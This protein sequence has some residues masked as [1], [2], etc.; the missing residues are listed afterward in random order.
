MGGKF[1]SN[2]SWLEFV[3]K[4]YFQK[5]SFYEYFNL[6][7]WKISTFNDGS[8]PI[9]RVQ[10]CDENGDMCPDKC[11]WQSWG[12]DL[13]AW[14]I[15]ETMQISCEGININKSTLFHLFSFIFILIWTISIFLISKEQNQ[16]LENMMAGDQPPEDRMNSGNEQN[17]K[18]IKR[19][20][21]NRK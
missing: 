4:S 7:L 20:R 11:K 12:D 1:S 9:L 16:S 3:F 17:G 6:C 2:K 21:V 5:T 18:W 15:D 14:R 13:G 10:D 8:I 19:W